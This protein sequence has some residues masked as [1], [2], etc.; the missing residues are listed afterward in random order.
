[1]L[2][3]TSWVIPSAGRSWVNSDW[4][5]PY[6]QSCTRTCPCAAT[7]SRVV[8]IAAMPLA[9]TKASSPPSSAVSLPLS[10]SWLGRLLSRG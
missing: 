3:I 8:E 4:V 7:A 2:S 5:P 1:M 9:V 10:A 6:K